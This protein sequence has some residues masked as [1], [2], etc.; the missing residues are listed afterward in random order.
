MKLPRPYVPLNIRLQVAARQL[1]PQPRGFGYVYFYVLKPQKRLK[2]LLTDIFGDDTV[3]LDHEPPLAVRKKIRHRDG[4]ITY[5]PDA[6]D[7]DFLI[8]RNADEHL[9]KTNV[10]G[11]GAQYPDRVRIKKIRRIERPR[12][13]RKYKWPSRPIAS[14]GKKNAIKARL[15]P[16]PHPM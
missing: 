2:A 3:Q 9:L 6:N 4:T 12:P 8:Y 7:P 15:S 16:K 10:R 14:K 13:K 1:K 5:V 11:D